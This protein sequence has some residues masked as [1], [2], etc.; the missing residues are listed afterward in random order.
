M[1]LQ[2]IILL[3]SYAGELFASKQ[4]EVEADVQMDPSF[5]ELIKQGLDDEL[6][7]G[8]F[9]SQSDG[10][11][12]IME[13]IKDNALHE[14][15]REHLPEI[16]TGGYSIFAQINKYEE[17]SQQKGIDSIQ[18]I[19][20]HAQNSLNFLKSDFIPIVKKTNADYIIMLKKYFSDLGREKPVFEVDKEYMILDMINVAC[21]IRMKTHKKLL[22][23]LLALAQGTTED[24]VEILSDTLRIFSDND[25][26]QEVNF[27]CASYKI[28]RPNPTF[29]EYLF[30]LLEKVVNLDDEQFQYCI[31]RVSKLLL[32]KRNFFESV[33]RENIVAFLETKFHDMSSTE[34]QE[35]RR[36]IAFLHSIIIRRYKINHTNDKKI[37]DKAKSA[38]IILDIVDTAFGIDGKDVYGTHMEK[39]TSSIADW[40]NNIMNNI[41]TTLYDLVQYVFEAMAYNF[42]KRAK[43]EIMALADILFFDTVTKQNATEYLL[44]EGSKFVRGLLHPPEPKKLW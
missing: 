26:R 14:L 23:R 44:T 21:M 31:I 35:M 15:L 18:A 24:E 12:P 6:E 30:R 41:D 2:F 5:I 39:W 17:R 10:D 4:V 28:C 11:G 33:L 29:S 1:W 9:R 3:M 22:K 7:L 38:F 20:D 27:M 34:V 13:I 40:A 19:A 8:Y 32:T 43:E 42:S 16:T 37:Q 25:K 36:I